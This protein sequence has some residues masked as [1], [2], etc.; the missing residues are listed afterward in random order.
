[1]E[2]KKKDN[3]SKRTSYEDQLQGSSFI[4][5]VK[6]KLFLENEYCQRITVCNTE[7]LRSVVM[8]I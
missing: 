7:E 6:K 3:W 8:N 4:N 1:M 5:D 2:A